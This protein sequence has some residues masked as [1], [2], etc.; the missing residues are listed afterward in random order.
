[1][2]QPPE[3][4]RMSVFAQRAGVPIPTIK[5]YLRERLLPEPVR[6]GRNMAYYD[7]ALIGRVRAI[8]QL[9]RTMM[10]PLAV[11]RHVIDRLDDGAV[12]GDLALEATVARIVSEATPKDAITRLGA[13]ELGVIEE[14]L[15]ALIRVGLVPDAE[16][17]R[18]DDAAL[19]RLVAQLRRA[20][21]DPARVPVAVLERYVEAL[22]HVVELELEVL[23]G[24]VGD[25]ADQDVVA[26]TEAA[27]TF[28]E[29]VVAVLR[30]KLVLPTMRALRIGP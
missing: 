6:T 25:A 15:D 23:R 21:L 30:R 26:R 12:P 9:Q 16:T 24:A 10:L 17:F 19:I 5:H 22:R 11:I 14:D 29:R 2:E 27:A 20:G 8:K 13:L 28:S 3:L 7:S 1:M 18:D 4:V